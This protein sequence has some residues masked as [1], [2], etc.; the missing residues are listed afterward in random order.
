M[1]P[2]FKLSGAGNDFLALVEP[3]PVPAADAVRSWCRR[4][5]S[6]GAD[7]LFLLTRTD[8]GARMIHFNADGG[9]A[10]LCLN[11]S[12]CAA[13]LAFHLGWGQDDGLVLTTDAGLLSAQRIDEQTVQLALPPDLATVP[14]ATDLALDKECH[15]G[16]LLRVGVPHFVLPWPESLARAPVSALGAG[17]RHHPELIPEGANIDFVRF[18]DR[19]HLEIRTFERG[20]EGETL[21]CGT[22]V[23]AAVV[24]GLAVGRLALPVTALT[25]SGCE[26]L[27]ADEV[28][29]EGRSRISLAGDARL[30]AQGELLSGAAA[31]TPAPSWS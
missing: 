9:R 11:G 8:S 6:L 17:L 22:G 4:S 16:F 24:T 28:D 12:R 19:H 20:V 31:V 1:T 3:T 27:L 18:T 30:L 14:T 13:Q 26:L 2:F 10:S 23:V 15:R 5:L 25:Q 29:T 21:A 7:G